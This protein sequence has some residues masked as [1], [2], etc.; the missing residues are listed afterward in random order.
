MVVIGPR[1]QTEGVRR[2]APGGPGAKED[3]SQTP[4]AG[5]LVGL[6]LWFQG[7]VRP[8]SATPPGLS[9]GSRMTQPRL[10]CGDDGALQPRRRLDRRSKVKWRSLSVPQ[11]H[12]FSSGDASCANSETFNHQLTGSV[13]GRSIC[14]TLSDQLPLSV[15]PG[16][17]GSASTGHHDHLGL[18]P[19]YSLV[20][21]FEEPIRLADPLRRSHRPIGGGLLADA[22]E[23]GCGAFASG[24]PSG[25]VLGGGGG[26][27]W[28]VADRPRTKN[29]RSA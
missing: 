21:I 9:A 28:R 16:Y 23:H 7:S 12:G 24:S 6:L 22:G 11:T 25:G 20:L 2:Q 17:V 8:A 10:A 4:G 19:A 26:W 1:R 18:W 5:H 15:S 29:S 14:G 27:W 3:I 13:E